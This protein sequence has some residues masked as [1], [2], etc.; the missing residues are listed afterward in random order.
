MVRRKLFLSCLALLYTS[1]WASAQDNKDAKPQLALEARVTTY[2][3]SGL[4]LA[5]FYYPKQTKLSFGLLLATHN[6]NGATKEWLFSSNN[7]DAL[8]IRLTWIAS[9]LARYH[10]AAHQ[11]GFF[12]ELGLGAE[13][14]R[15]KAGNETITNTNGFFAPSAG[16]IWYPRGRKGF[17]LLPKLTGVLTLFRA[18]EQVIDHATTFRLKPAFVTPSF[19]IGWKF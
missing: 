7:Y 5:A 16:Y 10:F 2:F 13:A 11:E 19:A 4:D 1:L 18:E 14:F 8:D 12:A 15:V 9:L 3:Q 17:Y 6:V